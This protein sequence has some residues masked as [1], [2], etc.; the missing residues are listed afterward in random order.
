M[1]ILGTKVKNTATFA[2][3]TKIG[4]CF[5]LVQ[6][7]HEECGDSAFVYM[8]DKKAILG[9]FDGVS[10]EPG[11][12]S[13]SSLAASTLLTYLKKYDKAD[14]KLIQ[15]AFSDV[16][17]KI[18]HGYTT[19][20]ICFISKDGSTIVAGVGDSPIYGIN[21]NVVLELPLGRIVEDQHSIFKY[22]YFRNIVT[23]VL[24][25]LGSD[26]HIHTREG[27]LKKGDLLILATD[28]LNDNLYVKI[29]E[30]Y[31]TDCSGTEDLKNIIGKTKKPK[32]I[33]EK[34]VKEIK[35]RIKN[36]K[37]Q[38]DDRMYVPKEDDLAIIAF[39]FK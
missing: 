36:G 15:K 12:A 29:R 7:G 16:N 19:A 18:K 23:S 11:A 32:L 22:F 20:T 2:S 26:I 3:N 37:V 25:P 8:D 14:E 27:K 4:E 38:L 30:G 17:K 21:D 9:V 5:C 33:V 10:G 34:L 1:L 13:A 31:L 24:G 28:C 39:R 6:R 35:K